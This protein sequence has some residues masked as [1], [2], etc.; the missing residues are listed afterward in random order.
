MKAQVLSTLQHS[1]VNHTHCTPTV[2]PAVFCCE[3][4]SLHPHSRFCSILLET[5]LTAPPTVD[6]AAL[7]CEP[8]SL[9]PH[10]R[11][12]DSPHRRHHLVY[13]TMQQDMLGTGSH[14]RDAQLHLRRMSSYTSWS[15]STLPLA[16]VPPTTPRD[17][18]ADSPHVWHS[19]IMII[20]HANKLRLHV[21]ALTPGMPSSMRRWTSSNKSWPHFFTGC[22]A[23]AFCAACS[24]QS[25]QQQ[26]GYPVK[27]LVVVG[28]LTTSSGLD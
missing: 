8:R 2:D 1:A 6:A 21:L 14:P 26:W 19:I 20:H 12:A 24:L 15:H 18:L 9:R 10:S 25:W 4:H 28:I 3:P 5:T 16:F 13:T 17:T 23:L 11:L 7:C 22:A 27:L